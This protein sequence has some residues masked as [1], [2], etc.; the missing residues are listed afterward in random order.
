MLNDQA[1]SD[2]RAHLSDT[3]D[4]H[5]YQQLIDKVKEVGADFGIMFDGDADRLGVVDNQGNMI[6]GDL[7]TGMIAINMLKR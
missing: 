3:T 2:F 4:P 7:V 6:G 1:D 5:D